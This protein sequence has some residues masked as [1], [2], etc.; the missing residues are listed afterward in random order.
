MVLRDVITGNDAAAWG[1]RLSK[2]EVI[3]AYPIT[4]QTT[5]VEKLSE[6]VD[7]GEMKAKFIA[8]ESEHSAMSAIIGA[9][10][11]GARAFTATSSHGLLYMYEMV[12]WAAG[13][14]TPVVMAV[15]NRALGP[16]WNIWSE[17]TD[18]LM[19]RDTG[20]IQFW[21]SNN[22]EVLDSIIQAYKVAEDRHVLLPAI[23]SLEG[24]V[25]SHTSMPV[26][27]HDEEKVD[28][29]L[30]QYNPPHY[31][32]NPKL[33]EPFAYGNIL[34]PWDYAKVR[35]SIQKAMD[36]AAEVIKKAAMEFREI[37]GH[38]HGD[39]IKEEYT[40]GA[41]LLIITMGTVA[42][43]AEAVVEQ[44][45]NN[46]MKV[47][48]VKVRV[49]RPFPKKEIAKIAN[50]VSKIIVI[51]RDISFG[52]DG[53]LAGEVKA[54]LHDFNVDTPVITKIMGIGGDDILPEHIEAAVK[55]VYK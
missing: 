41:E 53:I 30:P 19:T 50:E 12:A 49:F 37:F 11:A 44:L 4:P 13:A 43:E 28:E 54:T 10:A 14:R 31:I 55:E 3:A 45:R 7:K 42:E 32:V 26:I 20:W 21:A 15:V 5:I 24:F 48:C 47:G 52:W 23:V 2:V 38:W 27:I 16:P 39:L 8:V 33:S 46:G 40:D 29:Y 51:D 18:V 1:A 17:L 22:Q 34:F 9:S 25:L 6:W 35:L 36:N